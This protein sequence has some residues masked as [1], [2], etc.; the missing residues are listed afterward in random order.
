MSCMYG[1][2]KPQKKTKTFIG[3]SV[4]VRVCVSV[5][6]Y[7]SRPSTGHH[8]VCVCVYVC[9]LLMLSLLFL[10]CL[11]CYVCVCVCVC[12]C[13]YVCV[14]TY[15]HIS[16]FGFTSLLS[17]LGGA[18]SC[19]RYHIHIHTNIHT[20]TYINMHTYSHSKIHRLSRPS[21]LFLTFAH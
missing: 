13:V 7:D 18:F 20:N 4:C 16:T 9:V 14:N 5:R 3:A 19:S 11:F 21:L 2:P 8:G 10:S 1:V 12:V 15:I 6:I 17:F